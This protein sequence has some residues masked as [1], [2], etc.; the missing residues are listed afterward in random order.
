MAVFALGRRLNPTAEVVDDEMESI[1]DAQDGDS[2]LEEFWVGCGRVGIEDRRRTT[3]ED[4]A[5]G[6]QGLDFS[7]RNRAGQHDR[8][9]VLLANA[10]GDEL[11]ILRAEIENDNCLGVHVS[12][13]QEDTRS[14]K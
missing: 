11:G 13:W 4:E 10:A 3:G 14:G 1:T 12:V 2:K 5:D 8:K 9:D 7:E 6:F